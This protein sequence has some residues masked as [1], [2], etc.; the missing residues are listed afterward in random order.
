MLGLA[1]P[2][3][4]T[5]SCFVG[6]ASSAWCNSLHSAYYNLQQTAMYSQPQQR[7]PMYKEPA[8]QKLL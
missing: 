6:P 3:A 4:V 2:K 1:A 7:F 5:Q 8:R